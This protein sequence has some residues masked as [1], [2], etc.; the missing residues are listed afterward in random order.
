MPYILFERMFYM[1]TGACSKGYKLRSREGECPKS[2]DVVVR[3]E[4]SMGVVVCCFSCCSCLSCWS[5]CFTVPT[6]HFILRGL[7]YKG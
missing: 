1:P 3:Y 4:C 7:V 6:S 2:P 5:C